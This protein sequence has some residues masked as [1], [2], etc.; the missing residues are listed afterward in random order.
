[1][2]WTLYEGDCR[3]VLWTE[4]IMADAVITDPP[5]ELG[6]MGRTWDRSG[7]AFDPD[8]WR[9]VAACMKPGAH[10]LAFGA[11]RNYHRLACAIENTGLE[12]RDCLMW[13]FG[14][15]FPKSHNIGNGWGTALKPA[16]E[17]II[18]AR[19]PLIGTVVGNVLAHGT[20]AL[21]IDG[22]R[23]G[24]TRD[25]PA[26][27]SKCKAPN[28]IYGNYGG[29]AEKELDPNRG[30]WPA[31]IIHDGSEDVLAE[32]PNVKTGGPGV[33]KMNHNSPVYSG[34][35]SSQDRLTVG[36]NDNGSAARFFYC[37]K[38]GPSERNGSKHPTIKPLA[39]MRYLVRLIT[40]PGGLVL[41]PFAG[42]GTT[43]QAAAE[44]GFDAIGIEQEAQ[45]AADIQRRLWAV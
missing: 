42:T 18:L 2:T 26:S 17:P 8:T 31:N 28:S 7:V 21:N 33:T 39:L 14:T 36:Y 38:A 13:I 45:H 1:M 29:G 23:V 6:F 10:L 43:L 3:V 19:K 30:R 44:E 22:C 12:I 41:D 27:L 40:P 15:G 11:P 25:V 32:F 4:P 16:Y 35:A 24:T 34:P 20:G 5:Y 37:A 9:M